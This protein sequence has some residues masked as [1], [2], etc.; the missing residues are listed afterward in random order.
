MMNV[1]HRSI[2]ELFSIANQ[3]DGI[4]KIHNMIYILKQ[5]GAH[6]NES[7]SYKDSGPYSQELQLELDYLNRNKIIF[8]GTGQTYTVGENLGIEANTYEYIKEYK[9]KIKLLNSL[10]PNELELIATAYYLKQYGYDRSSIEKKL[11]VMKPELSSSFK[12][13]LK[14]YDQNII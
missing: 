8:N 9:D 2:R 1:S 12:S 6:F 10:S 5:I 13:S 14:I 7:F 11:K 4:G 3:I